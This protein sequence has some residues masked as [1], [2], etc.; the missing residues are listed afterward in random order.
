MADRPSTIGE[1][2]ETG[3]RA[4]SVKEELRGNLIDALAK[5]RQLFPGIVGYEATVTPQ[6]ENAVL[7]GQDIILLGERGQAKTRIARQLIELLDAS[8]PAI[9]GTAASSSSMSCRAMRVLAW[10]RSPRRMMSCPESTAFSI[11]GVTVASYPTMPGKSCLF[12]ASASM[13]LPRSSSFTERA[14]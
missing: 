13:R 7:S 10:P 3:Y 8:V 4:R 5:K 12:C 14:R 1:L 6:I 2:R 11:C 9:A